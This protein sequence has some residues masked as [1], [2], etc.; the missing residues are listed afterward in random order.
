MQL[1]ELFPK[2][3][4]LHSIYGSKNLTSI[5]GAGQINNPN[6][7]LIFMNPTS[8]NV[9]SSPEWQGI[10]APWLG[11]KNIWKLLHKLGLLTNIELFNSTQNLRPGEWT[12]DFC[13][14][15]YSEISKESIYITN[16]GK[17]TQDDARHLADSVYKDYL[18]LLLEELDLIQPKIVITLGNQV[19]SVLL[20]KPVS[21]SKYLDDEYE[22]LSTIS[23]P[24]LKVYPTFYPIGQGTPNMPKAINRITAV[25]QANN[26][27]K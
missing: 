10:R 14:Y 19:S 8:K 11:T 16:I 22:L 12:I 1:I 24:A 17:C 27:T 26:F 9:S 2:F 6:I 18:P 13:K 5:Y 15:V 21:V 25:L 20:Q 23:N 4:Q 7:C 3:D